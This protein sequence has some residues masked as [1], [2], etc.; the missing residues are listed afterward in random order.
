[1]FSMYILFA[2]E[3]VARE[4]L[5]DFTSLGR[6]VIRWVSDIMTADG[7]GEVKKIKLF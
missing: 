6:K 4:G 7:E 1:M 2:A 3:K 5:C